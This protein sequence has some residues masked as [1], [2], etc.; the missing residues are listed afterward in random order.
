MGSAA[1]DT[2]GNERFD[3]TA[4]AGGETEGPSD[5]IILVSEN[6]IT[7]YIG[8]GGTD[9]A[10]SETG[11]VIT[12][13]ASAPNNKSAVLYQFTPKKRDHRPVKTPGSIAVGKAY[14]KRAHGYR[15]TA[16]SVNRDAPAGTYTFLS[17]SGNAG[18]V[19]LKRDGEVIDTLSYDWQAKVGAGKTYTFEFTDYLSLTVTKRGA[20]TMNLYAMPQSLFDDRQSVIVQ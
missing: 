11:G 14:G 13:I 7:V 19:E 12:G 6:K 3:V 1:V 15:V 10:G 5:G 9:A 17:S 8:D 2:D 4:G 16:L 18:L 20:G